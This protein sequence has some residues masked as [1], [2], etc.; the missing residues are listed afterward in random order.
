MANIDTNDLRE[1]LFVDTQRLDLY[2]DQIEN[3]I[4]Y[5][6]VPE[7][8]VEVSVAGPKASGK[9]ARP[10]RHRTDHEKIEVL[11]VYL[12]RNDLVSPK[13]TY[14][15]EYNSRAFYFE[16][17]KASAGFISKDGFELKIWI[18]QDKD[19]LSEGEYKARCLIL[20][21][22][23]RGK[24]R[25]ENHVSGYSGL[26]LLSN[27]LKWLDETPFAPILRNLHDESWGFFKKNSTLN[28]HWKKL[29]SN[30]QHPEEFLSFTGLELVVTRNQIS[31]NMLR[32]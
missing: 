29:D 4:I 31:V 10:G 19:G 21:Q 27:E 22:D 30:S 32:L 3:P 20:I 15:F 26:R 18:A 5:D 16:R 17:V 2:L 25:Y 14:P 1:Y 24:E 7:W 13:R 28:C 6:K 12:T 11:G 23:F 9:Q 8:N